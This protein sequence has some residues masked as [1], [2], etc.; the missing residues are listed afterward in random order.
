MSA[1]S[2]PGGQCNRPEVSSGSKEARAGADDLVG[3]SYC[4]AVQ[5]IGICAG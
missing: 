5:A 3:S 4:S 1:C 2:W